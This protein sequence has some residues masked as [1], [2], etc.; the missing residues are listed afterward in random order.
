M[1]SKGTLVKTSATASIDGFGPGDYSAGYTGDGDRVYW[2]PSDGSEIVKPPP[3]VSRAHPKLPL[4][5]ERRYVSMTILELKRN[6]DVH[7][8]CDTVRNS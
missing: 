8:I 2:G 1:L 5:G 4:Q 6:V 7:W 3:A